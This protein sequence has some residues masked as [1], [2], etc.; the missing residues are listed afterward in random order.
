MNGFELSIKVSFVL[1]T[2]SYS[3][4]LLDLELHPFSCSGASLCEVAVR[5]LVIICCC[6]ACQ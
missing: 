1:A 4:L 3:T 6:M 2:C 5:G